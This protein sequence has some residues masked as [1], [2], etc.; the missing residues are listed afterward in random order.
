MGCSCLTTLCCVFGFGFGLDF[1]DFGLDIILGSV[2][3]DAFWTVL[4][5]FHAG[6]EGFG[7]GTGD[8]AGVGDGT[9][10]GNGT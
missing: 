7:L 4:D 9:G 8:G 3:R 10:T 5:D 1:V 2:A 6:A